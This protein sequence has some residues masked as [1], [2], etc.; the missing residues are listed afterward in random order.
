MP[1]LGKFSGLNEDYFSWKDT[2]VN[3]M[4]VHGFSL[5]L[6]DTN[7]VAQYPSIGKSIF[8]ILRTAVHGGQAQSIAQA[9][10]DNDNT[11]PVALWEGLETYYDTAVNR[12]NVVLFDV[13]RLLNIRLDPDVS[14]SSFVSDFRD[15]LQRLRKNKAKLAEDKDT[16]RALLLVAIQDDAF[17]TVR[18]AIV[19]QPDKSVE[20]IL[21]DIR[22]KET[23]LNIKDQAS[24][25]SGDGTSNLRTSRRSVSFLSNSSPPQRHS[26]CGESGPST[27]KKWNIPKFPDAWQGTVGKPF[28]KLLL[29]WR[30]TAHKGKTQTQ[31]NELYSTTVEKFQT[32]LTVSARKGQTKKSRHSKKSS[33]K[34]D[35]AAKDDSGNDDGSSA[36]EEMVTRKRIRLQKSRR[37]IT[38]VNA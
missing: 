16:L 23:V 37:V 15:C 19:Q 3:L 22:E 26:S 21:T 31:L 1:K 9:M 18:D 35:N 34:S 12:A 38:E 20:A 8:Y 11:D 4:G 14:G 32:A 27:I 13:R 33:S 25:V 29:E 6:T 17:E 10:V 7:E 24:S 2:T 36:G 5:F 28:F 30:T